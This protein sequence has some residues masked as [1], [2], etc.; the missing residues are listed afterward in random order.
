MNSRVNHYLRTL[1][2]QQHHRYTKPYKFHPTKKELGPKAP[3]YNIPHEPCTVLIE[4]KPC[5]RP[6]HYIVGKEKF[7]GELHKKDAWNAA[8]KAIALRMSEREEALLA[9]CQ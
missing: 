8:Q 2:S 6:A 1:E 3:T 5:G 4:G 7:C 9:A